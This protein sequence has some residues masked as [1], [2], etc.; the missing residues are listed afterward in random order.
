MSYTLPA[1]FGKY[2]LLEFLGG[3]TSHV[4]RGRDTVLD[5]PVAVKI[6]TPEASSVAA[7]K[8]RFLQEA[9]I[10]GDIQHENIVS[11]FDFGEIEGRPYM[12]MEYL[13]GEDL[14]G[15]LR[16]NRLASI[17]ERLKIAVQIARALEYVH[18]R[19]VI[20]R[21]IKP[22]NIHL[23]ANGRVKLMD[24]GIAQ[25][26]GLALNRTGMTVGTPYYMSPE[27]V[28]GG[29]VSAASDIYASGMLLFEM[30]TGSPGVHGENIEA[31]FYQIL[32]TPLDPAALEAAGVPADIR[33]LILECTAKNPL[34]RPQS[35]GPVIERLERLLEPRPE[36]PAEQRPAKQPVNPGTSLIRLSIIVYGAVLVVTALAIATWFWV[37]PPPQIPGMIY[38]PAGTF[39]TGADKH[40]VKLKAFYVDA[41]EVTNADYSDFCG[42][43]GCEAPQAARNLPVVNLTVAQARAFAKWKSE[44]LPTP[45]EWERAARGKD[46]ALFPWGDAE[47]PKLANVKNNPTLT[48][49]ELMPVRSFGSYPAFQM[50]GNAWEMVEGSV[51]PSAAAIAEFAPLLKPPPTV[52][53]PWIS[54]RGGSYLDPLTPGIVYDSA[55][56]PARFS[57]PNIGFR[58]VK[59]P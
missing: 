31:V 7:A 21:D 3:G 20:H 43:T 33:N 2:E 22:E 8:A 52:S 51:Q 39:L 15:A 55:A 12:A 36:P 47:D 46:G 29:A 38:I 45:L 59:N 42:S 9:R 28:S 44:R 49:H 26:A 23:D 10:A 14:R 11:V 53:E 35:F 48:R 19:G 30:L 27:Q 40:P 41:T 24:F 1:A 16:N 54:I 17:A 18:Q 25:T 57:G 4:Y 34:E 32:N 37:Q 56:I 6:L 58:C 5:R 50:V 13:R